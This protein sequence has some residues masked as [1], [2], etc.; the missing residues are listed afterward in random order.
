[1]SETR[2][3]P[4]R[5]PDRILRVAAPHFAG[6]KRIV[7]PFAGTGRFARIKL[8]EPSLADT[9]F[10]ASDLEPEWLI[11]CRE[12]PVNLAV[13]ADARR[14]PWATSSADGALT[15][16]VYP[17]RMTD[18]HTQGAGDTSV[19]NTY[20]HR[21]GR[22][23]SKGNAGA[24]RWGPAYKRLHI[25]FYWEM[26]R[27]LKPGGVLAVNI[28]NHMVKGRVIPAAEWH[29]FAGQ[30]CGFSLVSEER[31]ATTGLRFGAN[32]TQRVDHEMLYVFNRNG[33]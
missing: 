26:Y 7:D 14:L 28:K 29:R 12:H 32:H 18:S 3:H 11:G 4:A 20:T 2:K 25:Q 13:V 21:L 16:V 8:F 17:N 19:R 27:V 22:K 1:M 5:F 31:I 24:M 15:S 33:R 23:L 9:E 30:R 6:C 10:W